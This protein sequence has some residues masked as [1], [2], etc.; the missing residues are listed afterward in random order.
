[1]TTSKRI[2]KLSAVEAVA[3]DRDLMKALMKEAGA[4]RA[5][6]DGVLWHQR[7]LPTDPG[8]GR[9]DPTAYPD[10]LL[11]TMALAAHEDQAPAG[12]GREPEDGDP[13]RRQ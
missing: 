11:E 7:V 1:M 13:A 6:L 8:T 4:V 5:G 2:T 10:G 3:G 9:V 12:L